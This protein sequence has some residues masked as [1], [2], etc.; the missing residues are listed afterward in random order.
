[1]HL[2]LSYLATQAHLCDSIPHDT[3]MIQMHICFMTKHNNAISMAQQNLMAEAI[4]AMGT[5]TK[6]DIPLTAAII[7]EEALQQASGY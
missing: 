4:I 3:G 6:E 7:V 2:T 5:V 1:M